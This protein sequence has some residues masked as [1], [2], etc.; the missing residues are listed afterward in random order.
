MVE[1]Y[2]V[3]FIL[4]SCYF[5]ASRRIVGGPPELAN[6][7][8]CS[9][10]AGSDIDKRRG[11]YTPAITY[12]EELGKC[13][14]D[15]FEILRKIGVGSFGEVYSAIHKPTGKMVALKQ[16][17]AS[18]PKRKPKIRAEECYH[19]VLR[20]PNISRHY[21]TMVDG[22]LVIFALEL[23]E[24]RELR[25]LL[26]SQ[27]TAKLTESQKH[28]ILKQVVDVTE[29]MH[30]KG[31]IYGDLKSANIILTDTSEMDIKIVDFG[32]SRWNPSGDAEKK[33]KHSFAVDWFLVG[34]LYFELATDG[35]V[36]RDYCPNPNDW[37]KPQ[38]TIKCPYPA[39]DEDCK[40]IK[41][42]VLKDS[43]LYRNHHFK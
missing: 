1:F 43:K 32:L 7:S 37:R 8:L 41:R 10:A 34:V 19:H 24:G 25:P 12:S 39:T 15:D 31:I 3:L 28:H 38:L 22:D 29:Y 17:P 14:M 35:K 30:S 4:A 13:H 40:L 42:F 23:V 6:F 18:N 36:F 5:V 21:C 20:H 33:F 2:R 27:S 16:I 11:M 9:E 26:R